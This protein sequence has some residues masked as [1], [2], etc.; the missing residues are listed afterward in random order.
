[1]VGDVGARAVL[2]SVSKSRSVRP[3]VPVV[4]K[5]ILVE[6]AA[7]GEEALAGGRAREDLPVVAA[8]EQ[9]AQP[10]VDDVP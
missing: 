8:G 4:G 10:A 7:A 1:V 3:R 6:V 2:R 9:G 5:T